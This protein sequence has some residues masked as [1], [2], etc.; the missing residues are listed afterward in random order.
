MSVL[1]NSDAPRT[2]EVT[3]RVWSD[4]ERDTMGTPWYSDEVAVIDLAS[5]V[6]VRQFTPLDDDE[7]GVQCE[8]VLHGGGVVFCLQSYEQVVSAWL[9]YTNRADT[10][11]RLRN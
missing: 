3:S 11:A 9:R 7:E 1:H 10:I 8:V 5:V 2:I 4:P 6:V